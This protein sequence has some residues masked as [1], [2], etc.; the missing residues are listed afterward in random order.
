MRVITAPDE[1][2]SLGY[3]SVVLFVDGVAAQI[4]EFSNRARMWRCTNSTYVTKFNESMLPA[5]VLYDPATEPQ[6]LF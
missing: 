4:D 1:E 5:R 3:G 2:L 6:H